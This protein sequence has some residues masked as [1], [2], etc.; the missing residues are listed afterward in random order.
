VAT[1]ELAKR[2]RAIHPS[3]CG[4][5]APRVGYTSSYVSNF[6]WDDLRSIAKVE[7]TPSEIVD[8]VERKR[9]SIDMIILGWEAHYSVVNNWL[10]VVFRD[11]K[12]LSIKVV[13][14]IWWRGQHTLT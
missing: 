6:S 2:L 10:H 1:E 11:G 4:E 5:L 13:D 12:V 9:E 14:R 3:V 7:M 8:F